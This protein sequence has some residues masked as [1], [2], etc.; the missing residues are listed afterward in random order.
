M[1][2]VLESK[3]NDDFQLDQINGNYYAVYLLKTN[4]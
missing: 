4:R 2:L 3:M 1:E